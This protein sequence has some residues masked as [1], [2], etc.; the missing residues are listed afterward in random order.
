MA[1][2]HLV[3]NPLTPNEAIQFDAGLC[4]S[5]DA[6]VDVCRCSSTRTN[7]GSAGV[8]WLTAP[9]RAPSAWSILCAS[10]WAG[11]ARRPGNGSV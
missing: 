4:I 3:N 1:D 9:S 6:C 10:E 8:A 2:A 11:N 5:C 7:A